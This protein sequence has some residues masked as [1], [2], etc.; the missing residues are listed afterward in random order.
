MSRALLVLY[1]DAIRERAID[2][3]RRAPKDTRVEFKA[4]RRSLPQNDI[5]WARL[6]EIAHQCKW[7]GLKLSSDDWKIIFMDALNSEVRAVPN[8]GGNGFVDLGRSSS[9]L[10]KEEMSD[11][12]EIISEWGARNGVQF[13][14][15][16]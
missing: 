1:S 14:E 16:V 9:R 6:G 13:K 3:I 11:L 10:S 2:W 8:L 7:H 15:P 4:P 12:L 5:L